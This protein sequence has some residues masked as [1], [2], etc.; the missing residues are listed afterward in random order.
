MDVVDVKVDYQSHRPHVQTFSFGRAPEKNSSGFSDGHTTMSATSGRHK[1]IVEDLLS[2][3]LEDEEQKHA[4]ATESKLAFGADVKGGATIRGKTVRK[5]PKGMLAPSSAALALLL[6]GPGHYDTV[7]AVDAI[8]Q[9][10]PSV[11]IVA[12]KK[13]SD[14]SVHMLRKRYWEHKAADLRDDHDDM[15]TTSYAAVEAH[16]PTTKIYT[17]VD[18]DD[19]VDIDFDSDNRRARVQRVRR[20]RRAEDAMAGTTPL[21]VAEAMDTL[22]KSAPTPAMEAQARAKASTKSMLQSKPNVLAAMHARKQAEMARDRFLGPQ[23]PVAWAPPR[24]GSGSPQRRTHATPSD[25]GSPTRDV[26]EMLALRERLGTA[27]GEDGTWGAAVKSEEEEYT[28]AYLAG[29]YAGNLTHVQGPKMVAAAATKSRKVKYEPQ[30]DILSTQV[31]VDWGAEKEEDKHSKALRMALDR[32]RDEKRKDGMGRVVVKKFTDPEPKMLDPVYETDTSGGFGAAAKG[33]VTFEK[34]VARGEAVG[35]YGEKPSAV[36]EAA[37][38]AAKELEKLGDFHP[39]FNGAGEGL[40][41]ELDQGVAKDALEKHVQVAHMSKIP[42]FP[43]IKA[44]DVKKTGEAAG[45]LGGEW[46]KGM[47]D[48]ILEA[49]DGGGLRAL[50]F[51]KM[52]GRGADAKDDAGGGDPV[53]EQVMAEELGAMGDVYDRGEVLELD[54]KDWKPHKAPLNTAVAWRTAEEQPRW[55]KEG[56]GDEPPPEYDVDPDILRGKPTFLVD[57]GKG[58]DRWDGVG[59]GVENEETGIVEAF[60]EYADGDPGEHGRKLQEAFDAGL[61][62]EQ[63]RSRTR[64][65]EASSSARR[66]VEPVNMAKQR[67]REE[68]DRADGPLSAAPQDVDYDIEKGLRALDKRLHGGVR[69][70]QNLG[71]EDNGGSGGGVAAGPSLSNV[72]GS[73]FGRIE[74]ELEPKEQAS[75]KYE[76]PRAVGDWSKDTA[77]AHTSGDPPKTAASGLDGKYQY[78]PDVLKARPTTAPVMATEQDRF[79]PKVEGPL[80]RGL[81][82]HDDREGDNIVLG[83]VG[84]AESKSVGRLPTKRTSSKKSRG[85]KAP[86]NVKRTEAPPY[87]ER[88]KRTTVRFVDD[89]VADAL[90]GSLASPSP[91]Q[92]KSQQPPPSSSSLPS[93]PKVAVVVVKPVVKAAAEVVAVAPEPLDMSLVND[94]NAG[95]QGSLASPPPSIHAPTPTGVPVSAPGTKDLAALEE[96]FRVLDV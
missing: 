77:P 41:L 17:P 31:P 60:L 50:D 83:G 58:Q 95:G 43:E 4:A 64:A 82:T 81:E 38:E 47:A 36:A 80:V 86:R 9:H 8:R 65:E 51:D 33:V 46:F 93:S 13:D 18:D 59:V 5:K 14:V 57:M 53:E 79:M 75:S 66:M 91:Q 35:P 87:V 61:A 25:C 30:L 12:P 52:S 67:S 24:S 10:V 74:L 2:G 76:R 6:P 78:D 28:E 44:E 92:T 72:L 48:E 62:S 85:L 32:G 49:A 26:L 73:E 16:V 20:Q 3:V 55:A 84:E 63:M 69:F 22:A 34:L 1:S 90:K 71:R 68:E 23:L 45:R 88:V 40:M 39:D 27:G 21:D 19:D 11:H 29:Q 56:H 7:A 89:M 42:R 15:Q 37:A 70:E 54:V 94:S 96:S